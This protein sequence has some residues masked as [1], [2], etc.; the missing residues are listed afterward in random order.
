MSETLAEFFRRV[1]GNEILPYQ[2]RFGADPF[3]SALLIIPTGLG[4]TDTVTVPWLH[5][6]A[7]HDPRPPDALSWPCRA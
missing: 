7:T 5:A 6:V 2:E 4:K 1:T 3:T